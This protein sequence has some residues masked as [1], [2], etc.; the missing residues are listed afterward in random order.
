[1]KKQLIETKLGKDY[2]ALWE[3][4]RHT[5]ITRD[6]LNHLRTKVRG[7][8]AEFNC[9]VD[10]H[11]EK[12]KR[13]PNDGSWAATELK[14]LCREVYNSKGVPVAG[15]HGQWVSVEIECIF[16]NATKDGYFAGWVKSK[17]YTN[18]ITIKDDG[19][20]HP[21]EVSCECDRPER[22]E[23][24]EDRE[25]FVCECRA[26]RA[27][28]ETGKE[29]V[30]TFKY[31]NWGFVKMVCDK[32]R[33]LKARVNKTCGLHVHFDMR[34]LKQ[35]QVTTIGKRVARVVPA[36]KQ[37]LPYSR[38]DNRFC[39]RDINTHRAREGRNDSRYAFVNLEAYGRHKTLEIRGHSGTTD[40]V[41]IINWIRILR[42]V[43]DK[44]NMNVISGVTEMVS[45]FGF[46]QD[47]ADFIVKRYSKFRSARVRDNEDD[48]SMDD[49]AVETATVVAETAT[50]DTSVEEDHNDDGMEAIEEVRPAPRRDRVNPAFRVEDLAMPMRV[51]NWEVQV[52]PR[53]VIDSIYDAET[54]AVREDDEDV[55]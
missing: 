24:D 53:V 10:P 5:K 8:R 29:I 7:L 19:S 14:K 43:M 15:D 12:A 52:N 20:I 37:I 48:V 13:F 28:R 42:K 35:G 31:G 46:D 47:L 23:D 55:A 26:S 18:C 25:D 11:E 49:S 45:F 51:F 38:Q 17:G 1:M 36:L 54:R 34:H 44:R 27:R 9:D 16:P 4:S 21:E 41:K 33:E 22:D 3:T 30:I 40:A 6:L 39:S 2:A 32:L 50:V